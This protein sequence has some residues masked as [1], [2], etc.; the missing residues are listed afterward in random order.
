MEGK[1]DKWKFNYFKNDKNE[2]KSTLKESV[3]GI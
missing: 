3:K 2:S 1:S